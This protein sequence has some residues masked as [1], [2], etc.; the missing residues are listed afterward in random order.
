MNTLSNDSVIDICKFLDTRSKI[1]LVS[2]CKQFR[3]LIDKI[4]I[5]TIAKCKL[6]KGLP[7]SKIFTNLLV[8]IIDEI[9]LINAARETFG[10]NLSLTFGDNFDE[11]VTLPASLQSLTFGYSFNQPVTLPASLQSLTFGFHFNQP[12]TL[13]ASLQ[14]LTFGYCFNQPV[15]LP[16]SLQSLT[17]GNW[18]NQ[19]ITLP[20][21]LQ[22]LTFGF[23]FNQQVEWPKSLQKLT[24]SAD[25]SY[26]LPAGSVEI[27][28]I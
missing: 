23:R 25:Y 12:I 19:P 27:T 20:A 24:I 28:K 6:V 11:P 7:F 5:N 21:S 22:S 17:F 10:E 8:E 14:S 3:K 18:F 4:Q 15:T 2:T 26:A 13:P 1:A 16:A 9:H